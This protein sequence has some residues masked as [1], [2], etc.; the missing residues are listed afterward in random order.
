V[1]VFA[2][3]ADTFLRQEKFI[4]NVIATNVDAVP[5]SVRPASVGAAWTEAFKF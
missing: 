2:E 3:A 4:A 5:R 1:K